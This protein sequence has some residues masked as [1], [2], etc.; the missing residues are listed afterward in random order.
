VPILIVENG[1]LLRGN[2]RKERGDEGDILEAARSLHGLE[3]LDQVRYA[4]LEKG[5][6]I[7]IISRE[8]SPGC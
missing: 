5:G 1:R 4:I 6:S 8:A 2:M 3:R 7:S